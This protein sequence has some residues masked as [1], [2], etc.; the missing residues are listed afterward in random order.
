MRHGQAQGVVF[1][2]VDGTLVPGTTS[3]AFLAERVGHLD[4]MAA[5]EA[6]YA[7][8]ELDNEAVC[9][10]DARGYA[11]LAVAAV[12]EWLEDLPLIG[13]IDEAVTECRRRGYI[14]VI[15]SLAWDIVGSYLV[16]RF[17]FEAWCGPRLEAVD[18][19]FTGRCATTLDEW[20]KRD[21]ALGFC[22]KQGLDPLAAFAIGDSR[23]DLPLFRAVGASVALNASAAAREAATY[24]C[25]TDHLVDALDLLLGH[26]V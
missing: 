20:G 25:D 12:T 4:E 2:D 13:G 6:A 16:H 8:G 1:F 18:G 14:P 7:A 22:A 21:F 5:A 23:S 15:A 24:E 17:D 3:G 10:I 19:V 11:G 9:H 26:D